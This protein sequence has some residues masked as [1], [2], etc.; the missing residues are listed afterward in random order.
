MFTQ[1]LIHIVQGQN[2]TYASVCIL[3]QVGT[4]GEMN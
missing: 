1:L 4:F 2:G 3:P